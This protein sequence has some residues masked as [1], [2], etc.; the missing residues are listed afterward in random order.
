MI[1]PI[2]YP[3]A[4]ADCE[5]GKIVIPVFVENQCNIL[6][7]IP[8]CSRGGEKAMGIMIKPAE[9]H[10]CHSNTSGVLCTSSKGAQCS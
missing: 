10:M 8:T 7:Y 9:I 2:S 6:A 1:Y 3:N 4:Q 5:L